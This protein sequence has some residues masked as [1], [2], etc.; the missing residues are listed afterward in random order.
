MDTHLIQILLEDVADPTGGEI[1]IGNAIEVQE[2]D[3]VYEIQGAPAA[4]RRGHQLELRPA[5]ALMR[6]KA[7]MSGLTEALDTAKIVAIMGAMRGMTRAGNE[8]KEELR[9][10][11]LSAGFGDRLAKTW[12]LKIFPVKGESLTPAA[13]TSIRRPPRSSRPTPWARRLSPGPAA[14]SW[15]FQPTTRP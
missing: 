1:Q 2:S 10:Q 7:E 4:R 6:L 3:P 9:L 15:P 12:Q 13:S 8:L 5:V 14:S 11:I